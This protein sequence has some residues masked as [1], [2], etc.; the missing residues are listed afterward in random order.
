M[1]NTN[2]G[3]RVNS[4]AVTS[5][6]VVVEAENASDNGK[7]IIIAISLLHDFFEET[8][9]RRILNHFLCVY[10]LDF[11]RYSNITIPGFT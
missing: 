6:M 1:G 2:S 11:V 3:V 7:R 5:E 9:S 10:L 4:F 8:K